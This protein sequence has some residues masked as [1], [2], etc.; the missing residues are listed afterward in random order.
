MKVWLCIFLGIPAAA[1]NTHVSC[2]FCS[3]LLGLHS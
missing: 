2:E 1:L 3:R